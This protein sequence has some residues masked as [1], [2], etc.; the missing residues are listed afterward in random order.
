MPLRRY[1]AWKASHFTLVLLDAGISG[2]IVSF[3][4]P[5]AAG[6]GI[7]EIK[8]YLN[9][10]H[11]KGTTN[12]YLSLPYHGPSKDPIYAERVSLAFLWN[13]SSCRVPLPMCQ[14]YCNS[15]LQTHSAAA[16]ASH[17]SQSLIHAGLLSLKTLVFKLLGVTLSMAGGLIAG[18]EGPFIHTGLPPSCC[19][20]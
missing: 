14:G 20:R 13:V 1:I 11:I 3:V 7:P 2:C 18:K 8:T 6:S 5:L 4:A 15:L 19:C 16:Y 9:G 10:V 17:A 12:L